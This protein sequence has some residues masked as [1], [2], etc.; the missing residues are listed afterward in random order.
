MEEGGAEYSTKGG[1][2]GE[3]CKGGGGWIFHASAV[4]I[5]EKMALK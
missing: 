4:A 2:Y 1:W 5:Q 3:V